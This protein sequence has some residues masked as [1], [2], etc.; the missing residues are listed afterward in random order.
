MGFK[1][2]RITRFF[3][4]FTNVRPIL[5]NS[6]R[7]KLANVLSN[8]GLEKHQHEKNECKEWPHLLPPFSRPTVRLSARPRQPLMCACCL[9][10]LIDRGPNLTRSK[11]ASRNGDRS[12]EHTSE[13][14][15]L[16]Y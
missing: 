11:M 3:R 13:L 7:G 1:I 2:V 14:Q 15:S 6:T 4:S 10:A 8:G 12:E 5:A 16:A 9:S